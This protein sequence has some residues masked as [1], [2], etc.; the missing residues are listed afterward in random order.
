MNISNQKSGIMIAIAILWGAIIY[1]GSTDKFVLAMCLGVVLMFLHM[2]LGVAK[3]GV[4]SKKFLVYPLLIWGILWL[5]SFVLSGYYAE[6]FA[7][8]MPSFTVFG[9][10]PSFAATIFLYWIG[11]MLTLNV[12]L[13]LLKDEWLSEKDWEEF[14]K[15]VKGEK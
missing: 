10:H 9:F 4:V 2:I 8:V 7:G 6:I 13:D 11:G 14:C 3:N 5:V 15:R 12:G 1:L